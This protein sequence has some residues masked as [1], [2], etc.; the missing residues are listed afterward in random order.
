MI[1]SSGN[2]ISKRNAEDQLLGDIKLRIEKRKDKGDWEETAIETEGKAGGCG[3]PKA[4][5]RECF[6]TEETLSLQ[7]CRKRL[8]NWI[9]EMQRRGRRI[10]QAGA[11][12]VK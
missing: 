9:G 3:F 10:S 7:L 12:L 5:R 1:S 8:G 6:K 11:I 4:K 2:G